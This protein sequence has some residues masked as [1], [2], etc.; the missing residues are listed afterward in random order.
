MSTYT[1]ILPKSIRE[2]TRDKSEPGPFEVIPF[3]RFG[4]GLWTSHPV[5]F[6]VAA[7]IVL[8]A[9]ISL[10][11]ARQFLAGAVALGGVFGFAL[12]MIHR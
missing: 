6:V 12:W 3:G 8:I 7:G 2:A 9:L 11:E 5:G 10:P 1:S 4:A